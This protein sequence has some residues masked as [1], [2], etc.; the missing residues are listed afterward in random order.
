[1]KLMSVVG[2]V[3]VTSF[4]GGC[5]DK[6]VYCNVGDSECRGDT[7]WT[8]T[9]NSIAEDWEWAPGRDCSMTGLVCRVVES[10]ATCVPP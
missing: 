6:D 5:A 8:C 2:V 9:F 3:A 10:G 4:L 1:M 7:I